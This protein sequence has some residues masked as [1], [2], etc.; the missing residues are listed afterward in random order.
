MLTNKMH[1]ILN[2]FNSI[3]ILFMFRTF[4]EDC[5]A[6]AVLYVM[7]FMHLGRQSSVYVHIIA[8]DMR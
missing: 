2:L 5:I 4:Q 3:L 7:F 6:H 1:T 8:T